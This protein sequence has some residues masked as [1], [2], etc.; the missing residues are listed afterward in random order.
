MK[1]E[2]A[3]PFKA[4]CLEEAWD[5]L[6]G[7]LEAPDTP[8]TAPWLD[9]MGV[10]P[11]M[12][13]S[14]LVDVVLRCEIEAGNEEDLNSPCMASSYRWELWDTGGDIMKWRYHNAAE[15]YKY[16]RTTVT[17]KCYKVVSEAADDVRGGARGTLHGIGPYEI[18]PKRNKYMREIKKDVW[19]DCYDVIRA[20]EV[21]DPCLQH[22][23]KKALAA[24]KRIHKDEHEDLKDILASAKRA[25]EI[26]EEW[27]K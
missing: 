8:S 5:H 10:C 4:S 9:N 21:V 2:L 3:K 15:Y 19:V 23:L 25:L 22:L 16:P 26:Y 1:A 24:G 12:D 14:T 11:V 27:H 13:G 18:V 7:G 17:H 6:N 20:F